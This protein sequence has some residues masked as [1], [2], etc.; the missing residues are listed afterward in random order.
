MHVSVR[1]YA[2][3]SVAVLLGILSACASAKPVSV[4]LDPT[5]PVEVK[6][7][8]FRDVDL[9]QGGLPVDLRSLECGIAATPDGRAR[10]ERRKPGDDRRLRAVD[11]LGVRPG[12]VLPKSSTQPYLQGTAAV[13]VIGALLLS[14]RGRDRLVD[15]VRA[16]NDQFRLSTPPLAQS[17]FSPTS[18]TSAR[19]GPSR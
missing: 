17:P 10:L 19:V 14:Q 6:K 12:C 16:Y 1:Q 8:W 2:L 4:P 3:R 9:L 11:G 7:R 13:S 5:R 18:C 15:A